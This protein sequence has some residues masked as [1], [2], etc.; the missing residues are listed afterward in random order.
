M[1]PQTPLN[2][3]WNAILL[4]AFGYA[5]WRAIHAAAALETAA[6]VALAADFVFTRFPVPRW[7]LPAAIG[8]AALFGMN[9]AVFGFGPIGQA[10][11]LCL[12]CLAAAFRLAI[13]AAN[14]AGWIAMF[15]CGL[16]ACAA[17]AA[18]LLTAPFP[19]IFLGWTLR[20]AG[21]RHR[22]ATAAAFCAGGIIPLLPMA[23]LFAQA[24][25]TPNST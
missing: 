9:V 2:A 18:S 23:W 22:M 24:P 15:L 1:F 7:R 12:L 19:V 10:Y 25:D 21:H 16:F 20:R 14:G 3:F 8:T 11:G 6:A 13:T 5:N 4:R 17:P